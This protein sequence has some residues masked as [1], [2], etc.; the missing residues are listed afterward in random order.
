MWSVWSE[1]VNIY[2][3]TTIAMVEGR[4]VPKQVIEFPPT[5]P[6]AQVLESVARCWKAMGTADSSKGGKTP[7]R[8][9][10]HL[11]LSG[12][13]CRADAFPVPQGVRRF[14]ELQ[15]YFAG[16]LGGAVNA[17]SG[18]DRAGE[19]AR[20]VIGFDAGNVGVV[21]SVDGVLLEQLN[22][23][24]KGK[25]AA[26]R[27][28]RPLWSVATECGRAKQAQ[29]RALVLQELDGNTLLTDAGDAQHLAFD[30]GPESSTIAIR[31][32]KIANDLA[33][34]EVLTLRFGRSQG[35]VSKGFP[36]AWAAH[37]RT[38]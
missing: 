28:L 34:H 2:L 33:D 37:W 15:A 23:W 6:M 9:N 24:A 22:A 11:T 14:H 16:M 31:Q 17:D 20:S 35:T 19:G 29:I 32:W 3:G 8:H 12:A 36:N 26:I 27:T 5:W 21:A 25:A 1:S 4:G 13:R 7:K 10:L 30:A 38:M 18:G